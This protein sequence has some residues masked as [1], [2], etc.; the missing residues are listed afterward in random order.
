MFFTIK[1]KLHAQ[2]T[3]GLLGLLTM[4]MIVL[5]F[6][7]NVDKL[8]DSFQM[9]LNKAVLNIDL[10]KLKKIDLK[11]QNNYQTLQ[12]LLLSKTW[13]KKYAI[14]QD[15]KIVKYYLGPGS[16]NA[17]LFLQAKRIGKKH[18][19]EVMPQFALLTYFY[20][21]ENEKIILGFIGLDCARISVTQPANQ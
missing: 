15:E 17:D 1:I 20:K 12:R 18:N 11:L 13:V 8:K 7:N 21:D 16:R 5:L 19:F 3:I 4:V 14:Y 2:R 10:D 6:V 9:A